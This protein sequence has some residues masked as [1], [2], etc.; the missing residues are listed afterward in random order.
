MLHILFI[1]LKLLGLLLLLVLGLLLLILFIVLFVPVRYRADGTACKEKSGMVRVT[2]LFRLVELTALYDGGVKVRARILWKRLFDETVW[3]GDKEETPDELT[4]EF[5]EKSAGDFAEPVKNTAQSVLEPEKKKQKETQKEPDEPED[6][7][8]SPNPRL[9]KEPAGQAVE[10][11]EIKPESSEKITG[12]IRKIREKAQGI[13][14]MFDSRKE[15]VQKVREIISDEDNQKT[16]RLILRQVKK[17][18]RHILPRKL[19]GRVRF[20]FDDPSRTGQVLAAVSP[21]YGLYAKTLALEPVFDEKV[22][23]GEL[24]LKGRIRV[25]SLLWAGGRV[26]LNKNFRKQLRNLQSR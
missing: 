7:K 26:L 5:T 16:V 17:I 18:L 23:E 6:P 4:E 1:I 9:S 10:A 11:Q 8:L 19:C 15:K 21:F 22:L 3:S 14:K 12:F 24:H 25:W 20:G 13:R 2:W